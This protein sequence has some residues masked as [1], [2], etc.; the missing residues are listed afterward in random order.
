[1]PQ[2]LI[3]IIGAITLLKDSFKGIN[4]KWLYGIGIGIMLY[5]LWR[6]FQT[7]QAE[8]LLNEAGDN[9]LVKICTDIKDAI[10]P[11]GDILGF[12]IGSL[13]GTDEDKI[14]AA[15]LALKASGKTFQQL[16][17]TWEKIYKTNLTTELNKEGVKDLFLETI[18]TGSTGT[19][20]STGGTVNNTPLYKKGDKVKA[21][22]GFNLRRITPPYEP[23]KV[24]NGGEDLTI[25]ELP[26]SIAVDGK[27]VEFYEVE[28]EVFGFN[29]FWLIST[30]AVASFNSGS[31]GGSSTG[32]S[33]T[34]SIKYG[35]IV[36]AVGNNYD[37]INP[38][39]TIQRK[40]KTNE[41]FTV[42]TVAN[43][44]TIAGV[45]GTWYAVSKSEFTI[46]PPYSFPTY[47]QKSY[48]IFQ[49]GIKL[50]K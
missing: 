34:G 47:G 25:S 10:N 29:N 48:W 1:M 14:K 50:K 40:T 27:R 49:G 24:S 12:S 3:I 15:A 20:G 33:S 41:E 23:Y 13:D 19:G 8:T 22:A 7:S 32:G 17:E 9:V 36:V 18:A 44:K 38:N 46:T 16:A 45:T 4:K 37:L 42:T 26:V 5:F 2:Y 35:S 43:N 30:G 11:W 39:F 31:T 28:E 21:K 6:R